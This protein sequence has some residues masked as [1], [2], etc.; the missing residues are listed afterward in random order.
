MC[1]EPPGNIFERRFPNR[2]DELSRVT[3]DALRFLQE[4]GVAGRAVHVVHLA[5]EEMGTNILKYGYDDA[6]VHEILL[7][8][9]IQH[10]SVR[11]VLEDDGHEFNPVMVPQP[12]VRQPVEERLPGGLGI[13]LVREMVDQMDYERRGGRNR[14]SLRIR[15]EGGF[16]SA[17]GGNG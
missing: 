1:T 2:L 9:E 6:A 15:A 10:G 3:N 17:T 8:V 4:S 11:L 14:L 7:R 16:G 12:D 13:H 5:I